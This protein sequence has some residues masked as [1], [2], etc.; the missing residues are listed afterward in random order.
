MKLLGLWDKLINYGIDGKHL[1]VFKGLCQIVDELVTKM[2]IKFH[3]WEIESIL[4]GVFE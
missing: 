4:K 3:D 2:S 1:K